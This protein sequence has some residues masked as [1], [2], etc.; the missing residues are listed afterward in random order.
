MMIMKL[1]TLVIA[2]DLLKIICLTTRYGTKKIRHENNVA[3]KVQYSS[4]SAVLLRF[5]FDQ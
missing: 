3:P 2:V 4:T 5:H 1:L